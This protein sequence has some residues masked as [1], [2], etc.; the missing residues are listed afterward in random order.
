[1][2]SG[3]PEREPLES[4]EVADVS[5]VIPARDSARF[6]AEALAS[7]RVQRPRPAEIVVVDDGSVD[8]TAAIATAAG[9][10]RLVRQP[11]RGIAAARNAGIGA[12]RKSWLAFLDADDLWLPGKLELQLAA[13][14]AEPELDGVFTHI[15]N[16]FVDPAL[17]QR[18]HAVE[19]DLPGL[20]VSTMLVRRRSLLAVG[21][22][23]ESLLCAEFVDWYA[24]AV[25]AGT[26]FRVLEGV[27]AL[28]RIHGA[29]A[30]LQTQERDGEYVRM[31]RA[32]IVAR[33]ARD[34]ADS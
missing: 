2:S 22:F 5:V 9:D 17:R 23:D 21:G 24:R 8:D 7:I 32:R 29:N 25:D 1:M 14:A 6:L 18:F 31:L 16:E 13:L 3:A 12:A 15:R 34:R 20:H 10:V 27:Y 28:R 33:R 4:A 26:K 30:T 19:G 11:P